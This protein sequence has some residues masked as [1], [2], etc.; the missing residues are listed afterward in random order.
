MPNPIVTPHV[1]RRMTR[2]LILER[3]GAVARI[4][5]NQPETMNAIGPEMVGNSPALP[6]SSVAMK[7]CAASS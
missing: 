3:D 7:P 1:S 2:K 4:V 6:P 5:L